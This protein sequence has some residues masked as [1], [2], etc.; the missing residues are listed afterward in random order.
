MKHAVEPEV[1]GGLS[2][3]E[4]TCVYCG[5][6][7]SVVATRVPQDRS[8]WPF[9]CPECGKQYRLQGG[10]DPEVRLLHPRSDGKTDRYQETM[11]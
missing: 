8:P 6:R 4:K 3:F 5:A 1:V 10:E 2:I 7:L 11:F 9:A